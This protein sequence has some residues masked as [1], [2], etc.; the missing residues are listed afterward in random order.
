MKKYYVIGDNVSK[1]LS[2]T[3]F[4]YWFNVY[5][6]KAKYGFIE[7]KQSQF[8]KKIVSI[9]KNKK[10]SGLNITIPYK[11]QIIRYTNILDKHSKK[12][13]AVNCVT[14]NSKIKGTN[15]D[16]QGYF[17]TL[18]KN[19]KLKNKKIVLVGYG[20][21]ALAIHYVLKL[22]G[23]KNIVIFNRTKKLLKFEKTKKYTLNINKLD[24]HVE[25]AFLIINSIPKN[26]FKLKISKLVSRKTLLSDIVYKPK[27]TVFLKNF[28]NNEK[29]YGISMLIEQAALSFKVW[30]GFRPKVDE[31]LISILEK[32]IK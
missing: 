23:F 31:K 11:E 27:E 14:I 22:K 20:G 12:I 26:P 24:Q 8:D 29:I 1:S 16:W 19:K 3:I 30:F 2:P 18:P 9:L 25:N 4:N 32:K 5:K 6:I 17:K 7:I 13:N 21:A 28:P 15:T 10:A